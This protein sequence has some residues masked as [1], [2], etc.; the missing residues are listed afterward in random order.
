M[1]LFFSVRG[2][3]EQNPGISR[4][5]FIIFLSFPPRDW[6]TDWSNRI[7]LDNKAGEHGALM[8]RIAPA[9]LSATCLQLVLCQPGCS[10]WLAL[11]QMSYSGWIS[12]SSSLHNVWIFSRVTV[13]YTQ[14]TCNLIKLLIWLTTRPKMTMMQ[15]KRQTK[16]AQVKKKR[17][18]RCRSHDE[19]GRPIELNRYYQLKYENMHILPS[20]IVALAAC[21]C[22]SIGRSNYIHPKKK[23]LWIFSI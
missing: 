11:V 23:E 6:L 16:C 13:V 17:H 15:L 7:G 1:H 12:A 4:H 8:S 9:T 5:L 20:V 3:R 19:N 21:R 14:E 2:S 10:G 22:A 18:H